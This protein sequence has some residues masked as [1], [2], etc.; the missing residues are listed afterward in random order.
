MESFP[1][2]PRG[3]GYSPHLGLAAQMRSP[4]DQ[5]PAY[6]RR[7]LMCL[8][9]GDIAVQLVEH[10][11]AWRPRLA[12]RQVDQRPWLLGTD[13]PERLR[14]QS[15]EGF[16]VA[17]EHIESHHQPVAVSSH[18]THA[19]TLQLTTELLATNPRKQDHQELPL[20]E[21]TAPRGAQ[22]A[23]PRAMTAVQQ[24]V[25]FAA[26][27]SKAQRRRRKQA[28]GSAKDAAVTSGNLHELPRPIRL[29]FESVGRAH[30]YL[31]A[32]RGDPERAAATARS[33]AT[34][35]ALHI[36]TIA[37]PY[38]AFDVLEC[39]RLSQLF[40]NP[41]TYRETEHEG[42]AAI[43]EFTALVLAARGHRK[44]TSSATGDYRERADA[45]VQD[46][47][48][49][50]RTAIEAGMMAISLGAMVDADES[51]SMQ[52]GAL[53]RELNVRNLSFPHMLEDTL[54][55]LFDEPSVE[56][57]CRA[58]M[59]CT[60]RE[61]RAVFTALQSLHAERWRQ[62]FKAIHEFENLMRREKAKADNAPADYVPSPEA[63]AESKALW[64]AAWSNPADTSIFAVGVIADAASV[65]Q[66]QVRS[67]LDVF[68]V[69]M[70]ER[71]ATEAAQDFFAGGAPFRT[72]PLLR[73]PGGRSVVVHDGLLLPAIRK[74][75]EQKLNAA[76]RWDRYAKHRGE[77]LERAALALL[78]PHFPTAVVHHAFE[79]FIPNPDATTPEESPARFTKLVEG[80]GLLVVD[81]VALIIE[82]KA[83]A[84]TQPSR[85]GDAKRLARDLRKIV[86]DAAE[87]AARLRDRMRDDGGLRLRDGSWLD[88]SHVREAHTIAVSLEDLSGI[89]TVTS[90][91]VRAGVLTGPELPWTVSL[92]DLRI[93][94]ELVERPAEFLLYLR[95]RT[96]P[97]V[98][99][100]FH[101]IDELDF[102]LEF[103]AKGL[104][105]EP[106]PDRVM[107]ELP[108]F[109]EPTVATRRR[110]RQQPLD[111]LTSRTDGLDAWYFHEL[112][113]RKTPAP[114]PRLNAN[115]ELCTLID[116]LAIRG[117]PG[118][119][120]VGTTLLDL[121]GP[122]QRNA[123]RYSRQLADLSAEDGKPH[124]A[125]AAGGTRVNNS[126]AF[127]WVTV[128]RD[129]SR[130]HA[131]ENLELYVVAKKHQVQVAIGAGFL[132]DP[133]RPEAPCFTTYDNRAPGEDTDLDAVI[134]TYNLRPVERTTMRL[135]KPGRRGRSTEPSRKPRRR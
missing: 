88:L 90:E 26:V 130:E 47:L 18:L 24:A 111:M 128:G 65:D 115:P 81:D 15:I 87:Q 73:D 21:H 83:G 3:R 125:T 45:V 35:A 55:D 14:G 127:A 97:D 7:S 94:S 80:D 120:R 53:L 118:W 5:K 110:F 19:T 59:G 33:E 34:E 56:E 39:V 76:A 121:S 113:I 68:A 72:R 126:F 106:D 112:G 101:A 117:D 10:P 1:Y 57:D 52:L 132:F 43:I 62:R 61:I 92:H 40:N 116:A 54:T 46:V 6:M 124:S 60:V 102:F 58:A 109:G 4:L 99:R 38:D 49:E 74:R 37:E 22:P 17:V 119:L 44:G 78:S 108:Q 75:V 103:Y 122:V 63:L 67:A 114:K 70:A 95:R 89:A 20:A 71:D 134:A 31:K 42:S 9:G 66:E 13:H 135:P 107:A 100:R 32:S 12:V 48:N 41:E 51:T 29:A 104:Y 36:A 86:T 84:L 98:T 93:I 50:A 69:D 23:I 131:E 91:L 25:V 2:D 129:E 77:Y 27:T 11:H 85:A 64:D 123:A 16:L 28:R 79:Y 82:A 105:V 133:A 96:E 30:V 8:E